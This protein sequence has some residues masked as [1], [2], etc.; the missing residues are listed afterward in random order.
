[1]R[2]V[3]DTNVIIS[4]LLLD[5]S[6][7][8]RA[9]RKALKDGLFLI[10]AAIIQELDEVLGRDKFDPYVTRD[11]RERFLVALLR[12]TT[13]IDIHEIVQV[14]RDHRDDKF[15]ELAINGNADVIVSGD[16]DLL[17]LSPFRGIPI[18]KPE[19]FLRFA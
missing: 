8:A 17:E 11:E 10:S 12:E 9:F 1:M 3:I 7:P 2:V 4:A 18:V 19:E 13:L 6:V 15:L 16:K 14:C 5:N